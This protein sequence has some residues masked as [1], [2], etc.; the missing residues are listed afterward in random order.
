[1]GKVINFLRSILSNRRLIVSMAKREVKSQYIGSALGL[2]W[3]F[4]H[5]IVLIFVFWVVFSVGFRVIPTNNVPFVVW[6]TAGMTCWF[7]FADI[8]SGSTNIIV[9]HANLIKKTLFPSQIL[10]VVKMVSSLFAHTIFMGILIGLIV[11]QSMP[12]SVY[13][14]QALYYLFCMLFFVSGLTWLVAALN[15]FIRDIGQVIAL[16]LQVG[17]WAT[18][19]FWDIKIMPTK[20]QYI[21]KLNPMFYIVQGYRDSFFNFI[22]F[23]D[24][25][26]L[27]FY[28]WAVSISCFIFGIVVFQ[29]LQPQFSDVL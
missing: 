16:V 21:L 2:I 11:L 3:T 26:I 25:P 8:L 18:P 27:T 23:W 10:P 15:V 6:L 22:P 14:I 29:R 28:F 19:I 20:V 5:P 17:F 13:F 7:A 12:I 1:M 24:R 4:I 9:G